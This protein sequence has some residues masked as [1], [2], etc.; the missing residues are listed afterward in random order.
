MDQTNPQRAN[1]PLAKL[2]ALED[3]EEL[4]EACANAIEEGVK[5]LM[6]HLAKLAVDYAIECWWGG[7]ESDGCQKTMKEIEDFN[8]T[9]IEQCK[10]EGD[11]CTITQTHESKD[12]SSKTEV[13]ASAFQRNV[14]MSSKQLRR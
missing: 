10:E 4:S 11:L 12:G 3:D 2:R 5:E 7:E 9:M 14:T 8:K 1:M 13:K 6:K